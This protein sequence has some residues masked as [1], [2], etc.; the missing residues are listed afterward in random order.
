MSV[1]F[2][3]FM[4]EPSP[5]EPARD[6]DRPAIAALHIESWRATYSDLLGSEVL[7][8]PLE[9]EMLRSW[10]QRRID[11]RCLVIRSG[12]DIVG[13]AAFDPDHPDGVF[14]DNLH[15]R[16][17]LDGNG[18]GKR[19]MKAVCGFAGHR[20]LWLEVLAANTKTRAIYKAWG[21][22][23]GPVFDDPILGQIVPAHRVIWSDASV[24][25]QRLSVRDGQ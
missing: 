11:G 20:P 8:A 6:A 1:S 22:T 12:D 16:P 19:L 17:G 5:P 21:G 3:R 24:L 4:K 2:A 25:R 10:D 14:L 23:E 18:F 9:S 13:F 7:G 15:V